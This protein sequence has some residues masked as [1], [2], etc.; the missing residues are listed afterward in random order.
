MTTALSQDNTPFN[1][2]NVELITVDEAAKIFKVKP[3]TF[4][5]WLHRKQIPEDTYKKVGSTVRIRTKQFEIF[6]NS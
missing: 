5:T 4:R 2:M 3:S 1:K 6:I